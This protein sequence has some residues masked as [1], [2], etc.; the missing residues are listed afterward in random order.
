[1]TRL[2]HNGS[3]YLVVAESAK[4][5]LDGV[6]AKVLHEGGHMLELL[7]AVVAGVVEA[8]H[9]Q[10]AHQHVV[11]EAG[12]APSREITVRVSTPATFN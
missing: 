3:Q 5:S 8:L 10:L 7:V 11:L 4:V 12:Q 1:M 6:G 9:R 2:H